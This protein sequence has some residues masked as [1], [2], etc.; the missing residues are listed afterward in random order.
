MTNWYKK[1]NDSEFID[2][3]LDPI[4][5]V[6]DFRDVDVRRMNGLLHD[7]KRY[8]EQAIEKMQE[9]LDNGEN[10]IN[11]QEAKKRLSYELAQLGLRD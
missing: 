2:G 3:Y 6:S 1:A 7:F 10:D 8:S 4:S 5:N 11:M 9:W